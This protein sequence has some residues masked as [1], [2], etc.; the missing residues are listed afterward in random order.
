MA[1]NGQLGPAA[2]HAV[3]HAEPAQQEGAEEC[4]AAADGAPA[5]AAAATQQQE[6]GPSSASPETP[7][8]G[9][10]S[11]RVHDSWADWKSRPLSAVGLVPYIS[12]WP[13]QAPFLMHVPSLSVSTTLQGRRRGR[14]AGERGQTPANGE[15]RRRMAARSS[16]RRDNQCCRQTQIMTRC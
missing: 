10:S 15:G 14:R 4:P 3:Q 2:A 13:H 9:E 6:D 11:T 16:C 1:E 12:A 5:T 8:I 7:L